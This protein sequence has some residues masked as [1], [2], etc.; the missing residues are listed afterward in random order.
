MASVFIDNE[1]VPT[2]L[3]LSSDIVDGKIS[4]CSNIGRTVYLTDTAEWKI[5]LP[6]LTLDDFIFP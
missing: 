5:I 2:Y 1:N 6:N 3:A 4:G